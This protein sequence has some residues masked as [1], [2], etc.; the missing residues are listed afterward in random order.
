MQSN[1]NLHTNNKH[2]FVRICVVLIILNWLGGTRVHA[3][4]T[5]SGS[6]YE[7]RRVVPSRST[8]RDHLPPTDNHN[9]HSQEKNFSWDGTRTRTAH[10]D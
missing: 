5:H 4:C 10:G 8:V 6:A 1:F 2:I 7:N 3:T 9:I